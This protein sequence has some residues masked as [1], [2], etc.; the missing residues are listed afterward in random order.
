MSFEY[1][2]YRRAKDYFSTPEYLASFGYGACWG[3]N[4]LPAFFIAPGIRSS[5]HKALILLSFFLCSSAYSWSVTYSSSAM[6]CS[7]DI[8][9]FSIK[10][11]WFSSFTYAIVFPS[12]VSICE[13]LSSHLPSLPDILCGVEKQTN[14]SFNT[15]S[16]ANAIVPS[17]HSNCNFPSF[18]I[19]RIFILIFLSMVVYFM[20][21]KQLAKKINHLYDFFKQQHTLQRERNIYAV[22]PYSEDI[23]KYI[24]NEKELQ[25]YMSC[26]LVE[27]NITRKSL[28]FSVDMYFE[29]RCGFRNI[30]LMLKGQAPYDAETGQ[31]I[32]LHHIGQ[33]FD[34]PFAELP[35]LTHGG[36]AT[37]SLLHNTVIES[38]R[39]DPQKVAE[40]QKEIKKYWK[41]RGKELLEY[42][43]NPGL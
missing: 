35:R 17:W 31:V 37:Y 40:T 41:K 38:W 29:R 15:L 30:D 36:T 19:K 7:K 20:T 6:F 1:Y 14:N 33:K 16:D 3:I 10:H 34:S 28:L 12:T 42:N 39:L 21:E 27:A 22:S 9:G 8:N 4:H 13:F 24:Q 2:N 43:K 25:I 18:L 5:L 11:K 23:N 26:N 32:E